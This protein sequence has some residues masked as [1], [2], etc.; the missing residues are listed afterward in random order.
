MR[1]GSPLV[2]AALSRQGRYSQVRDNLRVKEVKLDAAPDRRWVICHN[3]SEA[4]RDKTQRDTAL[5][6]FAGP[7]DRTHGCGRLAHDPG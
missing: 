7:D 3:P 2:E 5:V 1:D 6:H 4:E